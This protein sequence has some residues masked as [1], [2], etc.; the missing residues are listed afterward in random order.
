MLT[1]VLR[2]YVQG[3]WAV[4]LDIPLL[5][6]S[7][8]DIFCGAV[9]M[10][11][12]TDPVAQM[13]RLRLRDPALSQLEAEERVGS[14]MPVGEKVERCEA[15]GRRGSVVLNVGTMDELRENVA[16]A[17]EQLERS[18]RWRLWL[19]LSPFVAGALAAWEVW[20]GWRARKKWESGAVAKARDGN[21][22]RAEEKN[23]KRE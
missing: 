23:E 14:Q 12:V 10:V 2:Y 22:A 19:W 4:V 15:R 18:K 13:R 3:H 9:L 8:L 17:M 20:K 21:M 7:G 1:A 5:F 11:A 6:E 16:R